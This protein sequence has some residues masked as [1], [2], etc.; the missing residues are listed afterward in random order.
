MA[1]NK[2]IEK[3]G[4][5][6]FFGAGWGVKLSGV[7][8]ILFLAAIVAVALTMFVGGFSTSKPV[9]L[10]APRAGLVMD[11]DAKVKIR[12]VQI[13]HVSD[14]AYTGDQA[15]LTLAI[16]PDQLKMV[17]ANA[18]VDIRSTTVFGA[19][20]VNFVEPEVPSAQHLQAGATLTAQSVTVEFN[21]L[22]QHLTDVLGKIAPE[23]LNATLTALGTA[24]Q[25]RGDKLGQL[26]V[27]SDEYLRDINP[28]LP[29]LQRDL[30]TSVGVTN[31]YADTA[32]NLLRTTDNAAVTSKTIVDHQD[33]LDAV[34][35]NLIGLADTTGAVLKE[36]ENG[37]STALDLLRP[38]AELLNE[39]NPALYCLVEGVAGAIPRANEIFGGTGPWVTLN[40]S[41]MPGGTPYTYPKDLPKVNATGGP[42]C[43][44]IL[45]RKPGSHAN[46]LVTDTTEGRVYTPELSTHLNGPRVFQ[47]L[48]A[49]LPGVGN[50]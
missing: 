15:R 1:A 37:L 25:G 41:F 47:L 14:I 8:L 48:F 46:Y 19:K 39:Y 34:L 11:K 27:D 33:S 32:P 7:A 17:P 40:A 35:L 28:S 23:K 43:E 5:G 45:D 4:A 18:T 31:L 10:D 36:N 6:K 20:Y 24:L 2:L 50:P 9:Y 22:F 30:Q 42:H 49:G 16:E 3:D 13:G 38:T 12:G 44:G 26:L 21:T 29:D